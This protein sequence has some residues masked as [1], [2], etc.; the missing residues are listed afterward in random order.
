PAGEERQVER[1]VALRERRDGDRASAAVAA[2]ETAARGDDNL[3][4]AI[5][6]AARAEVTL[7]EIAHALRRTFGEHSDTGWD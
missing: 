4:P 5:L 3:M 6:D 2:L 7:G 1:L